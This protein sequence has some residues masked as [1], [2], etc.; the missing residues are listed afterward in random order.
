MNQEEILRK[1]NLLLE[2]QRELQVMMLGIA[3]KLPDVLPPPAPVEP[4]AAAAKVAED[5]RADWLTREEVMD[6]KGLSPATFYR[7]QLEHKA[8]WQRKKID[9]IWH[10]RKSAL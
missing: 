1:V 4:P 5:D 8:K 7:R 2:R 6:F 9:G 10:Y 3:R